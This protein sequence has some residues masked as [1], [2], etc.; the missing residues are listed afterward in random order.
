[1]DYEPVRLP[2]FGVNILAFLLERNLGSIIE[3]YTL[4][5]QYRLYCVITNKEI[6]ISYTDDPDA[7][8]P[9]KEVIERIDTVYYE[10]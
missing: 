4:F 6:T 10:H 1:M 5:Q 2:Y 8:Q 7:V 9:K 3:N